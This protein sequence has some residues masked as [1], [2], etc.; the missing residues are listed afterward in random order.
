MPATGSWFSPARPREERL[1]LRIALGIKVLAAVVKKI[2]AR[3]G[4]QRVQQERTPE[5]RAREDCPPHRL[6]ILAGLFLV[7]RVAAGREPLQAHPSALRM[8]RVAAGVAWTLGQEDRLYAGAKDF[9]IRRCRR[10]G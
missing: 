1:P 10:R 6:E 2:A 9:E 7:P 4:C 8:A 3:L 5:R